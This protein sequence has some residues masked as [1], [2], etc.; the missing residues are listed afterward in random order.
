MGGGVGMPAELRVGVLDDS[1]TTRI[2]VPDP[3]VARTDVPIIR[4]PASG[5]VLYGRMV[6]GEIE[7]HLVSATTGVDR[8][9]VT[10]PGSTEDAEIAPGGNAVYWI[11]RALAGGGVWRVDLTTGARERILAPVEVAAAPGGI[12]LAA[13]VG[14]R[15]ELA[16]SADGAMLAASW[17]GIRG[18]LLQVVRFGDDA[19][20][21]T[22]ISEVWHDLL[23]FAE[24][25]VALV[26]ACVDPLSQAVREAECEHPDLRAWAAE[27]QLSFPLG[28]EL[29]PGWTFDVIPIPDAPPMSFQLQAV[30]VPAG[31]GD[32]VRLEVLGILAGQG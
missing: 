26:G 32:P 15:A 7:L 20:Q 5:L 19:I 17:C 21:G 18:C 30:A 3:W 9:A 10:V 12:V 8:A 4:G 24:D 1:L 23:G 16:L 31:G 27:L 14:P 22:R 28:V 11:D 2:E 6:A 13:A 25:G 29:P